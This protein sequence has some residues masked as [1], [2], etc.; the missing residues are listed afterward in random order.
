MKI[1]VDA[2][3]GDNAPLEII[4][5][6]ADAVKGLDVDIVLTGREQEIRTV[7]KESGVSLERMEICDAP[8]IITMEDSAG[9]IV[10]AKSDSS[11]AL[12]LRLLAQG[13]GDAFV[14]GGNSGA[15]VVGAT[16]IVKRIKGVRR[17]AFA[18]VMP[19]NKGCFMLIDSGANVDCKPEML[20]Q[21]GIMG[22]IYM[23]KVMGIKN[24][25]VALANIGTEDHKG[26]E[27]QHG[28]FSLLKNCGLNFV[29]NVE[30]RDIP[31]DA[32]DVI[33]ADGFTGNVILKMFE[34][35]AMMLMGKLKNIFTHSVKNKLAAAVL[36]SDVKALKKN[37]DYN[38]YG[39]A[40]LMGCSRPVFKTHG[41]AK[42]KTVYNAL[43]LTKAYVE[44][45]VVDE[46]ASSVAKYGSSEKKD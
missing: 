25:R 29:G 36:L 44:G 13:K 18:P 14:S 4:K 30:A 33:V 39:G 5:G 37:F 10:K 31:N 45:N 46:I 38:E 21:F 28:A 2:F 23:E 20:Q 3:G 11:M 41:S 27:L 16:L 24:P 19:K 12:G 8:E 15:L 34:G 7:A 40:P 1:I 32:G 43:R 9:D 17:I 22:S 26:G 42:A 35:V 6:C